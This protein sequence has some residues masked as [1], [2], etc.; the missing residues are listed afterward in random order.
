MP[1]AEISLFV[2]KTNHHRSAVLMT[3]VVKGDQKISVIRQLPGEETSL[4]T[5]PRFTLPARGGFVVALRNTNTCDNLSL[6]S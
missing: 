4:V 5:Q 6:G 1:T 2:Q 3:R